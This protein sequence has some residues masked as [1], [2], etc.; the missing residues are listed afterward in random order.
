MPFRIIPER[1]QVPE[2]GSKPRS[3]VSS[4]Q[5]WYVLQDCVSRSKLANESGVLEPE[6][7]ALASESG[8]FSGEADV[9][10]GE[11]AAQEIDGFNGS[12]INCANISVSL[13]VGPV[14]GEHSLTVGIDFDKP[15]RCKATSSLQS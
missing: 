7:A 14:F 11:P 2:N 5:V 13:N 9:L 12:P 15:L 1:G 10:A 8:A 4:K 3:P 6:S